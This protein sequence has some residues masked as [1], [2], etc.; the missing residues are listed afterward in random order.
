MS[1]AA[2]LAPVWTC[3]ALEHQQ[4]RIATLRSRALSATALSAHPRDQVALAA[5]Q[6]DDPAALAAIDAFESAWLRHSSGHLSRQD[7]EA[8][9]WEAFL[10]NT[11]L[12]VP[13]RA[14]PPLSSFDV[15]LKRPIKGVPLLQLVAGFLRV[16]LV[17]LWVQRGL[18]ETHRASLASYLDR[19]RIAAP[20]PLELALAAL[21]GHS[22]APR[23][24]QSLEEARDA[25]AADALVALLT[26]QADATVAAIG[27]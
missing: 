1:S 17:R 9:L 4:A 12:W 14:P 6:S 26:T 11:A 24:P 27:R 5:S 10:W 25:V 2:P 7:F 3:A 19:P 20:L 18:P 8:L 23:T 15:L 22:I 16:D 13:Y 21:L